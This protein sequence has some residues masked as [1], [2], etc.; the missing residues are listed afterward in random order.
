M[1][2]NIQQFPPKTH[3][4]I[5]LTKLATIELDEKQSEFLE[6]LAFYYI[7]TRYPEEI[8]AISKEINREMTSNYLKKTKEILLWLKQ[9]IQ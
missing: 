2:Q 4:L 5:K 1:V 7:Q 9:K 3:N 6:E 8:R